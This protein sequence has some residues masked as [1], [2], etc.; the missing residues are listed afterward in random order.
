[1][2]KLPDL[3]QLSNEAKEA[4]I[5]ELWQEI[6]KLKTAL[7]AAKNQNSSPTKTSKNSSTPPSIGFKKD[8][9][10]SKIQGVKRQASVGRVG[11]GRELHPNPDQIIISQVKSCPH[12]GEEVR[13]EQQKLLA[14]Y[15][16]IELPL[17]RPIISRIERYG[18]HCACCQKDYVAPVPLGMEPGSP[19]GSSIQSLATYLRY[20]HAISYERLS[21]LFL[22]V[23]GLEISEGAI[24]NLFETVKTRLD[25][26]VTEILQRLQRSKLI[27]SDET[28]ARVNGQN[29]WEWV[30]QNQEVCLHVIRPSRGAGVIKE[31]LGEHRPDIWVS[32]LFSAQ[33]NHPAHQWQ[34]CLAH[35]LRD[36]QY[37]IDAGDTV[38]APTMKKLLLRAF[39]IHRRS[40]RLSNSTL[41]QYRCDLK[42]RL[43]KALDLEPD[44]DDGIRLRKRYGSIKDHLFVFLEDASIPPTNNSSEQAIRMSTVFRKVTNCF[45]SQWGRDLFAA[46]RSVVNTGK[47][48]GLTAYQAIQKALSTNGSLFSPS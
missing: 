29:Q 34:V 1:M 48:Q 23:F 27:C 16:K 26:Q 20:T 19:F 46:V 28:G 39:V 36:C 40:E 3:K 24:A 30:F 45:R 42:R 31:I 18:G 17:I 37:A 15:E 43:A 10:P 41:Y 7:E 11:G 12:C 8:I 47:R 22:Q 9:K 38:F 35:Q 14:I 4:L 5:V 2:E 13:T 6:E 21:Q 44:H 25:D 33:K 32:D